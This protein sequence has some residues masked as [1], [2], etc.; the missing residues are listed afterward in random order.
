M[1]VNASQSAIQNV[2]RM[3]DLGNPIAGLLSGEVTAGVPTPT[4]LVGTPSIN[5]SVILT[6]TPALG[7]SGNVTISYGRVALSAILAAQPGT[8]VFPN[9]STQAQCQ[10][11][12][13]AFYG[14]IPG[15][16]PL[17]T[18]L[19]APGSLPETT[20]VQIGA[21]GSLVYLDGAVEVPVTWAA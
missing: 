4:T 9:G 11:A 2:V 10:A 15:E 5:T 17:T 20:T 16:V 7:Y 12:I 6:G 8:V 14:L 18:I 19:A 1:L 21:T 13:E 3:V